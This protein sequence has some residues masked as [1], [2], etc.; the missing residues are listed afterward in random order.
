ML[1]AI[2]HVELSI[3]ASVDMSKIEGIASIPLSKRKKECVLCNTAGVGACTKCEQCS[4]YV[5]VSCAWSAGYKFGFEM[6]PQRKRRPRE[7]DLD[8]F[9]CC[10]LSKQCHHMAQSIF[11]LIS[12]TG[13]M[14]TRIWCTDH[15]PG[16]ERATHYISDLDPQTH[17]T[18]LQTYIR[19][20]KQIGANPNFEILR[21]ARRLDGVLDSVTKPKAV[22]NPSI[23]AKALDLEDGYMVSAISRMP[24]SPPIESP[25]N[26]VETN[27]PARMRKSSEVGAP[28]LK[29][30]TIPRTRVRNRSKT[31]PRRSHGN[32]E[33][34]VKAEDTSKTES[35]I[36]VKDA[37]DDSV[38]KVPVTIPASMDD[39][40]SQVIVPASEPRK[41]RQVIAL[42]ELEKVDLISRAHIEEQDKLVSAKIPPLGNEKIDVIRVVKPSSS[43]R[44]HKSSMYFDLAPFQ[45]LY[46]FKPPSKLRL[47]I[48][49]TLPPP[50]PAL[51][52]IEV[53]TPASRLVEKPLRP[54]H[55]KITPPIS[56]VESEKQFQKRASKPPRPNPP[57]PPPLPTASSIE[58]DRPFQDQ[59]L[60]L[61]SAPTFAFLPSANLGHHQISHPARPVSS[62]SSSST[63]P[64]KPML[65]R[66]PSINHLDAFNPSLS[67]LHSLPH[68]SSQIST[69]VYLPPITSVAPRRR[70]PS[71]GLLPTSMPPIRHP[72]PVSAHMSQPPSHFRFAAPLSN[73]PSFDAFARGASATS[74]T[75][76]V[77]VNASTGHTHTSLS[78]VPAHSTI[79]HSPTPPRQNILT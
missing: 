14:E 46:L 54:T 2:W 35:E 26:G 62:S 55:P 44:S 76:T 52:L 78:P 18:A 75:S 39:V 69:P 27:V 66:L 9:V 70:S 4:T 12:N 30:N 32:L 17:M 8:R 34:N 67:R 59:S 21:K 72:S 71:I 42:V 63:P 57:P 41:P 15:L 24:E 53:E 77:H 11:A 7:S 29:K 25:P 16:T 31:R 13:L 45:Q 47:T 65:T 60:P 5:H 79:N 10:F 68:V 64:H 43:K 49:P 20:R 50:P 38:E 19:H 3:N 58:S 73:P 33:G 56:L 61:P 23:W 51:H 40:K 6:L 74:N 37:S 1:C 22:S 28:N 48:K 36:N